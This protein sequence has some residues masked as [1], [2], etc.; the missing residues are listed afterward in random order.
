ML[1][2]AAM[3]PSKCHAKD[4]H[5]FQSFRMKI[6]DN[7]LSDSKS[8]VSG[9]IFVGHASAE[10]LFHSK[11]RDAVLNIRAGGKAKEVKSKK[12]A[13]DII[14]TSEEFIFPN[15]P[16]FHKEFRQFILT[17][18][19]MFF[20]I[21]IFTMTRDTKDS[22]VVSNCGAEAIPFLKL[23]GVMPAAT[24]FFV[25]YSKLSNVLSKKALFYATLYP[26]FI[27]YVAFAFILFP[28]RNKIHPTSLLAS[29]TSAI[30]LI[31]L[32]RYWSF[33]L[34]FIVTELYAG[35]GIPLLFWQFANDVT[36]LQ[37]AKRFYPLFA[38]IGNLAPI[39]SGKIMTFILSR[40]VDCCF[41]CSNLH[42]S[43][44]NSPIIR[45][46]AEIE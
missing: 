10:L 36:S 21:I 43:T 6:S 31:N 39:F 32:L 40:Y 15:V 14:T 46:Q 42:K 25:G 37:Q 45:A 23:Y 8:K 3:I 41:P 29:N 11:S 27:F 28:T 34:Y 44:E 4:T 35:A 7:V 13:A 17:S 19:L 33:S 9:R 38:V 16:I 18:F 1:V 2:F 5:Q 12:H 30:P 24:L 26:F 22:L 20:F